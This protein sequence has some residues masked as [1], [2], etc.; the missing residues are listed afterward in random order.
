[1]AKLN[2]TAKLV[3]EGDTLDVASCSP[4]TAHYF[5]RDR[6]RVVES[7]P[8][9]YDDTWRLKLDSGGMHG[10]VSLIGPPDER[11]TVSRR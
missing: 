10:H 5:A 9:P 4:A 6:M 3:R 8:G 11:V 1:M 2:I 7:S